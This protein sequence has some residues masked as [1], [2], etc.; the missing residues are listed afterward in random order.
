MKKILVS[1]LFLNLLFNLFSY[2]ILEDIDGNYVGNVD[3]RSASLGN[4]G[5]AG[6]DRLFDVTLNPANLSFLKADIGAQFVFLATKDDDNRS[7]PM[8]NF[9]DGYVDNGTYVSNVNIYDEMALG[10]YYK[11]NMS[12]LGFS[13][14]L[15]YKP[16]I[17]FESDYEEQ[18]RNDENSDDDNYPPIIAKNFLTGE[19][20]INSL[21]I[22]FALSY[23]ENYSLGF[24][25]SKLSGDQELTKNIVWTDMGYYNF[26]PDDPNDPYETLKDYY[27]YLDR[28]FEAI[29]IGLGTVAKINERLKLGLTYKP[30]IKFDVTGDWKVRSDTLVNENTWAL[31]FETYDIEDIVYCYEGDLVVT[32]SSATFTVTDSTMLADF[33][34]PTRIKFGLFYQPQNIMLTKFYIDVEYV[35][36]EDV[37]SFYENEFNYYV[38]VEHQVNNKIPFRFGFKY[39]TNYYLTHRF[40]D[41]YSISFADKITMPT[42][43][44]GTG[45]T[46]LNN[47]IF[48]ISAEIGHRRYETLDLFM[49]SYYSHHSLWSTIEP[50]DRGWENPDTVEETLLKIKAGLSFNW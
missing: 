28:E 31:N 4:T 20:S 36:W 16:Y 23:L 8:Y 11:Y 10:G 48:D 45:F 35:K 47:L 18:V 34:T 24:V 1:L 49:D 21:E 12:D 32:D 29:Q 2:S 26:A 46:F 6:G 37:N 9:F 33:K 27:S 7:I 42:F 13:A 22:N 30:S 25:L 50:K 39:E 5:V 3:S 17:N 19:G 15:F 14:G 44:I 41:L 38:G 40:I 43:T